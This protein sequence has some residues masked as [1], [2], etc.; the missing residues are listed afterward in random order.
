MR[1]IDKFQ[2]SAGQ[3]LGAKQIASPNFNQRPEDTEIQL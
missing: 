1:Y 3:L 2:V